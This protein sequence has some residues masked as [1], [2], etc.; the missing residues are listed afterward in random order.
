MRGLDS[1]QILGGAGGG[2]CQESGGGGFEEGG[3]EVDTLMHTM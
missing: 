2:A 3:G 1:F